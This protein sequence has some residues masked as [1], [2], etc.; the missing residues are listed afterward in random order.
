M[1]LPQLI[2]HRGAN[3]I[4]PENTMA[5]FEAAKLNHVN[6]I[7]L[8]VQLSKDGVLFIFH[9][10]NAK[11]L[12][13]LDREITELNWGE[14]QTL[15]V[16]KE[17][18]AKEGVFHIPK[19]SEYLKWMCENPDI[20]ANIEIKVAKNATAGYQESLVHALLSML[21]EYK[22]LKDRILLSSFS[23][24]VMEVLACSQREIATHLLVHVDNWE[25]VTDDVVKEIKALYQRCRCIAIAINNTHLTKAR[26]TW[27]KAQFS[28]V[29][30]YGDHILSDNDVMG[31]I[32][33]NVD[34]IFIDDVKQRC[35]IE[36]PANHNNLVVSFLATGDEIT[37]GDIIN[38][39]T[40]KLAANLYEMG[41]Q[42][43]IHL[44]A[45]DQHKNIEEALLFLLERS[46]IVITVGGLGPTEDD[47]T[48]ESI[49]NVTNCPLEFY[50]PSWERIYARVSKR[51]SQV[52][53]INKKQA[54][55][56]KGAKVIEN[57]LGTADGCYL[58]IDN[59]HIFML[60]GPPSECFGM[61][62]DI[63]PML[64]SLGAERKHIYH[65]N[66]L[67]ASE[68]HIAK[69]IEPIAKKYNE[70]LGYRAAY[71]YL[72]VKLHSRK[73]KALLDKLAEEIDQSIKIFIASREKAYASDILKRYLASGLYQIKLK[74]DVTKGYVHSQMALLE[75]II[76]KSPKN[77]RY[78][79]EVHTLGMEKFWQ[80]KDAVVDTI[81][82]EI[83]LLDLCGAHDVPEEIHKAEVKFSNKGSESF[84]FVY[85]WLASEINKFITKLR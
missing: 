63:E 46:D 83:Q 78:K 24:F 60:P 69:R 74:R 49:A 16:L 55:F 27:L 18:F 6:W 66:L 15:K 37:T 58:H 47:K 67:G 42:T 45:D 82:C 52:P 30:V 61:Y 38:T 22:V 23:P 25:K 72:E 79:I 41:F 28:H 33:M 12:T 10:D 3:R 17:E 85:E 57:A 65:W 51:F 11:R 21:D 64:Q 59:K 14:I 9:D 62:R 73:E 68:A 7:E 53:E 39:N 31:L 5:A 8:D 36:K 2:A 34:S 32:D 20:H 1:K 80:D 77:V 70:A 44:T 71:P 13:L 43:A 4:F 29:L 76:E 56:P 35:L 81:G 40:P 84:L 26:V 19:L 50:A 54:Y 48:A 75:R